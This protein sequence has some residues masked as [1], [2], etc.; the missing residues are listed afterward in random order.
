MSEAKCSGAKLKEAN[1]KNILLRNSNEEDEESLY[2]GIHVA[3][4]SSFM[5]YPIGQIVCELVTLYVDQTN[6]NTF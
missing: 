4:V 3:K 5:F 6:E 1:S 2:N